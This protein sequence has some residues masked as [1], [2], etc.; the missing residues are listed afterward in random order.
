MEID[1]GYYLDLA[2]IITLI[3]GVLAILAAII[4]DYYSSKGNTSLLQKDHNNIID[5]A[6]GIAADI[7]SK[8]TDFHNFLTHSNDQITYKTDKIQD[9]VNSIDKHLAVEA[10][11]RENMEKNLTHE[12][13]DVN[14]QI[15]AINLLNEQMMQLQA[16]VIQ[17]M[18]ENQALKE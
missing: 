18:K 12:Q 6:N 1:W 15:Q 2:Q 4:K 14:H 5:K 8:S 3:L 11:R 7:K 17:L 10:V 13:L 9:T 16:K